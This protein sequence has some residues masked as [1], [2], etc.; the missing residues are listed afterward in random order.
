MTAREEL[1]QA[2]ELA[3]AALDAFDGDTEAEDLGPDVEADC[4]ALEQ[5]PTLQWA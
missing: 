1:E 5:P 4:E 2:I 3:I